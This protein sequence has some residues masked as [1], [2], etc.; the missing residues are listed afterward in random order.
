MGLKG[1]EKDKEAEEET[2]MMIASKVTE[3]GGDDVSPFRG[4]L[5]KICRKFSEANRYKG[6]DRIHMIT[7]SF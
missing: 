7:A 1:T 3:E 5:W 6:E 4:P 2:G